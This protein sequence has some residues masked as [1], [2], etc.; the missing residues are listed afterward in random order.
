MEIPKGAIP[1]LCAENASALIEFYKN[2]LGAKEI[3]RAPTP[4]GRLMH[5]EVEINGTVVYLNDDFPEHCGGKS[6]T[7]KAHNG[8][9]VSL[10]LNVQNCDEAFKKAVAAG[11]KPMMEPADMFW[12]AR[13]ARVQDPSGHEWAFMHPLNK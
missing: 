9:P 11:A 4:D 1:H 6:N 10:H 12:G 3:S 13:Y 8:S 7:P 2:A 5:A